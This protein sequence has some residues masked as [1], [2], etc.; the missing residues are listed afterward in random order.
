MVNWIDKLAGW[1]LDGRTRANIRGFNA[2]NKASFRKFNAEIDEDGNYTINAFVEHPSVAILA[3]DAC[4]I[5]EDAGGA[6]YLEISLMPRIDKGRRPIVLTL[7]WWS[8]MT[9]AEKAG[10]LETAL[11]DLT[12]VCQRLVDDVRA[13]YP[14]GI[15]DLEGMG[16]YIEEI[17]MEIAVANSVMGKE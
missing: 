14:E 8:G 17:E 1:W 16:G 9:P 3:E 4:A 5:L 7:R 6:N 10:K 11:S 13:C 12:A 2:E 15:A